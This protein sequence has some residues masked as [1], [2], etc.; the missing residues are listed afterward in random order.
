MDIHI[1]DHTITLDLNPGDIIT[2]IMVIAVTQQLEQPGQALVIGMT[3]H[4]GFVTQ[5]GMLSA[6]QDQLI[7]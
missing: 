5:A 6:V 7:D 3:E 2:D 1:G 4:T